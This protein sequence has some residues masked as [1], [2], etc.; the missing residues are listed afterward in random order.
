MVKT[1][2][3]Y[4]EKIQIE[5]NALSLSTF[6]LKVSESKINTN[7]HSFAVLNIPA[8]VMRIQGRN[9]LLRKS[10]NSEISL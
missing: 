6:L 1:I 7:I 2:G 10:V 3:A 9:H 8:T 5:L 4:V